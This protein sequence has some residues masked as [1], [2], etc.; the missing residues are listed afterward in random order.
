VAGVE[1]PLEV[2]GPD[3]ADRSVG[4]DLADFGV[5]W[6]VAVVEGDGHRPPGLGL[7]V[8][9]APAAVGVGRHGLLGDEVAA[10]VQ[11]G[12]DVLVVGAVDRGD[13]DRVD[14]LAFEHRSEV[15]GLVGPH[16]R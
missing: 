11:R 1:Q 15:P 2:H 5:Y 12:D 8:E 16:G 7:G 14:V 3:L 4:D 9:D 10:G 13:H 6:V